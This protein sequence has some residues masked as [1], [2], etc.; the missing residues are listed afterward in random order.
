MLQQQNYECSYMKKHCK[1]G[2]CT[3]PTQK[4]L[5]GKNTLEFHKHYSFGFSCFAFGFVVIGERNTLVNTKKLNSISTLGTL[6]VF[7]LEN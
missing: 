3:L 4:S 6:N 7:I 1:S 5:R 2:F